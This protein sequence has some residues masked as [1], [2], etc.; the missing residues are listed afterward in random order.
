MA[1]R[2]ISIQ[3]FLELRKGNVVL[4]VR[5]PG[6]FAH[7]HILGAISMP[8]FT[9]E[10]R[11]V[12]GTSYKQESREHAIKIGLDYFGV[13]MRKMVEEVERVIQESPCSKIIVHCWRGGMRSAGVAWLLDLY[14]FD[15]YVLT[16]GYKVYRKWVHQQFSVAYNFLILSGYTGSGKTLVLKSLDD[17]HEYV[18]DLEGIAKHRGSSFGGMKEPQPTQEMF[19]NK[20]GEALANLRVQSEENIWIEDE[21]QRIGNL[22]IPPPLW[23][24][25]R[26][27]RVCFLDVPF[28]ERLKHI[29]EEYG[30]VDK[31]DLI[32]ATY[33]I[34]KRLGGLET[35][36][37]IEHLENERISEAFEILL[38]YYDKQYLKAFNKRGLHE[39][40]IETIICEQVIGE[41]NAEKL[42]IW[43]NMK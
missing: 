34:Q 30:V 13:K 12:V 2:K 41:E 33:R 3:E 21:S 4:D 35:K 1:I 17:K 18:V 32:E 9:D 16:G 27:G 38:R 5:S 43:K 7:A 19:E 26:R 14:G 24:M 22:N 39:H 28:E 20:L 36:K 11:K 42:I 40:E 23:Q 37:C 8:L 29:V 10:E 6:E 15:V 25:M 31:Q